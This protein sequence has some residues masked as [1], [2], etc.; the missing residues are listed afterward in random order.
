MI[1]PILLQSCNKNLTEDE[2][3]ELWSKAQTT[4]QIIERSGTTFSSGENKE[5][6]LSDA[7]NRLNTGGG[8]LGKKAGLDLLS[9]GNSN[10][11]QTPTSI[12]MPINPFFWKASIET[13]EFMPLM[14]AD[15]FAGIIITDWHTT[16]NAKNERCKLNI[17]I[18]GAEMK[19]DNLRVNSFCQRLINNNWIDQKI[20]KDIN[21]KIENAILNK[22]KKI[23]LLQG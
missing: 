10:Q 21:I 13:V 2:K 5:L 6:A 15:P 3:E 18:K 22:A 8:L 1:S 7:Q 11:K 9:I 14:S 16:E 20:N 23:R 4:G 19:S 17:F 12:G